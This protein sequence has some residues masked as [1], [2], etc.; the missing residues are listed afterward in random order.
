MGN[1]TKQMAWKVCFLLGQIVI[2]TSS[3]Q[4]CPWPPSRSIKSDVFFLFQ[5]TSIASAQLYDSPFVSAFGNAVKLEQEHCQTHVF[6]VGLLRPL[7]TNA[8]QP[9][10]T[11]W[12]IGF[13]VNNA[14]GTFVLSELANLA[15]VVERNATHIVPENAAKRIGTARTLDLGK[16][17]WA[18]ISSLALTSEQTK[19]PIFSRP[20]TSRH[21]WWQTRVFSTSSIGAELWLF[22]STVLTSPIPPFQRT[23]P[24]WSKV[25]STIKSR[26]SC[27]VS[28]QSCPPSNIKLE[29]QY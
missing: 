25:I 18:Q 3:T 23:I 14:S 5:H 8:S 13:A 21:I 10:F 26:S 12:R 22:W 4:D 7:A 9:L 27:T 2:L 1:K 16:V 19:A 24:L 28:D 20:R 15:E 17:F 11:N 29:L 6:A